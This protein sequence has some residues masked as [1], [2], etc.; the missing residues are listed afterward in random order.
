MLIYLG[1]Q[2]TLIKLRSS[3]MLMNANSLH[4]SA[5]Q[6]QPKQPKHNARNAL[7][8]PRRFQSSHCHPPSFRE[9]VA[10]S[11]D[12]GGFRGAVLIIYLDYMTFFSDHR[13]LMT[14]YISSETIVRLNDHIYSTTSQHRRRL[15]H[16][17]HVD[18]RQTA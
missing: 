12:I 6:I 9:E 11:S 1:A 4:L 7:S 18:I 10:R 2:T 8:F 16:F 3:F 14:M 13:P 15:L 17:V 5:R